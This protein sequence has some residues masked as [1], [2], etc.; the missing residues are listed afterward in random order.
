MRSFMLRFM[1]T[2]DAKDNNLTLEYKNPDVAGNFV[3]KCS[4]QL[5]YT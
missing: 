4:K 5:I 3:K 1:G 2:L